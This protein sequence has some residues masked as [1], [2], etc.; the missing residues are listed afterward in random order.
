MVEQWVDIYD[1]AGI[2]RLG[3][4]PITTAKTLNSRTK[5]D[6]GGTIGFTIPATDPRALELCQNERQARLYVKLGGE[7]REIGRG[8]IRAQS[9]SGDNK[10]I[11]ISG[12]DKLDALTRISVGRL[13]EYD[14]IDIATIA[15]DL[16]S[17]VEGWQL[18]AEPNLGLQNIRFSGASVLKALLRMAKEKGLHIRSG[19]NP[20]EVEIGTFGEQINLVIG[21]VSGFRRE[22]AGNREF[23]IITRPTMKSSTEELITRLYPLGGGEGTAAITL[24]KSTRVAPYTIGSV[25]RGGRTEYYIQNDEAVD[26]YGVI[27]AYRAYKQITPISNTEAGYIAAANAVYDAGASDLGRNSFE[28]KNYTVSARKPRITIRPGDKVKIEY[29]GQVMRDNMVIEPQRID[30][31][32]WVTSVNEQV[33]QQGITV[34]LTLSNVDQEVA[35][36]TK[37][38][39][40]TIENFEVS[41]VAVK[42]FPTAF[43]YGRSEMIA[44][45]NRDGV[46]RFSVNSIFTKVGLILLLIETYP[47]TAPTYYYNTAPPALTWNVT[48]GYNYPSDLSIWIDGVDRTA[49]LG[50]NGGVW[51]P[52]GLNTKLSFSLNITPYILNATGGLYQTHEIV[53]KSLNRV[54]EVRIDSG[55]PST[56]N[57]GASTG[58]IDARFLVVGDVQAIY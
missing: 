9:Y 38:I 5:L 33:N 13:R 23:M 22:L 36:I 24:E 28:V 44:G 14:A 21:N 32:F 52:N 12:G 48:Q 41:N 3:G 8:P 50:P 55:Y 35:D 6:G 47:L 30:G 31:W 4:G 26:Q 10:T 40:D 37:R 57:A 27:E 15:A 17:E 51:N 45:A 54:G 19:L 49:E 11:Q 25:V 29:T 53:F 43:I 16:V 42:T 56:I 34:D 7:I 2:N 18:V 1:P 39:A 46:F 20:N 58:E